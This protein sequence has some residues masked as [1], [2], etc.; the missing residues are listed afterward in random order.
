MT[1]SARRE[2][3]SDHGSKVTQF[4]RSFNLPESCKLEEV[5]SMYRKD[6]VLKLVA[7][8]VQ[9]EGPA[10]QAPVRNSSSSVVEKTPQ[11]FNNYNCGADRIVENG[12]IFAVEI[13]VE[14]FNQGD[15]SVDLDEN[16]G[17]LTVTAKHEEKHA[18]NFV[19]RNFRRQYNVPKSCKMNELRSILTQEGVLRIEAPKVRRE[20]E[21]NAVKK[22]KVEVRK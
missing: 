7:P 13:N 14:G 8:K 19:S 9:P 4:S 11:I 21:N 20:I 1:V 22:V 5:S 10:I 3:Q 16:S 2:D 18:G 15:L 12:D 17:L 6:G